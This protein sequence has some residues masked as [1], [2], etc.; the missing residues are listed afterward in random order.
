MLLYATA[1]C[2]HLVIWKIYLP[3]RQTRAILNIFIGVLFFGC[4]AFVCFPHVTLFGVAAPT[5]VA[6]YIQIVFL[7]VSLTMAYIITYSAIEAD[8]PSIVIILKIYEAGISGLHKDVLARELNNSVLILPRIRDL[9]MD[10]MATLVDGRYI[11]KTKG[12][13]MVLIVSFYRRLIGV[14]MGG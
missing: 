8:S 2:L 14:G 7:F 4:I 1:F 5:K 10:K 13:W 12:V 6:E 9:V 3:I 11:I